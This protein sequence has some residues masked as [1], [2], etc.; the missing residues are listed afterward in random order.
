MPDSRVATFLT[1]ELPPGSNL[2]LIVQSLQR[3]LDLAAKQLPTLAARIQFENNGKPRK[4]MTPGD[5]KLQVKTFE[6]GQ[7]KSYRELSYESFSLENFTDPRL[8]PEDPPGEPGEKAVCIPRLNIIPGGLILIL[9]FSHIATDGWG[10]YLATAL[11]CQCAKEASG[12]PRF[13]FD[14]HRGP[15]AATP[16]RVAIGKEQLAARLL[17]YRI[18]STAPPAIDGN[19][20]AAAHSG[21]G[22]P[23]DIPRPRLVT[24][25]LGGD[26]AQRL[27][28]SIRPR[29]G[30][31]Y[32]S[33]HDCVVALVWRGVMRARAALNPK[34]RSDPDCTSSLLHAV[35]LRQ[36][37]RVVPENYFGNAITVVRAGPLRMRDLLDAPDGLSMAASSLRKSVEDV[38]AITSEVADVTAL[39]AL[40]GPTKRLVYMPKVKEHEDN[41]LIS[42]TYFMNPAEYDF[43]LGP[44]RAAR[45]LVPPV[46]GFAVVLPDCER[47]QHSRVYD[48]G[49]SLLSAEHY[50][51]NKDEE[52]RRYFKIL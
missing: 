11:V 31:A 14:F 36:R 15:L 17:D 1:Y 6:P 30:A 20:A 29:D 40:M 46:P 23:N 9:S 10:R 28:D 32:V 2:Q 4:Q 26:A 13:R 38:N 21:G 16:E 37:G 5:L 39:G 49:L 43:G 27:K 34:L 18:I 35:N 52:F 45:T 8:L 50:H 47:Q 25:R 19:T 41:F 24:Y 22:M 51:L 48:I 12:I 44:P 7:H 33:K 3:G 42:S